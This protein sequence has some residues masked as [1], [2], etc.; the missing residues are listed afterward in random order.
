MSDLQDATPDIVINGNFNEEDLYEHDDHSADEAEAH[1][2]EK[3]TVT[4]AGLE[5]DGVAAKEERER[6]FEEGGGLPEQPD[7]PDF[8][9]LTPISPEI[10]NR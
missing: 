6:E 7:N 4:F 2:E 9:K 5:D 3:K 8:S 1:E 10:I